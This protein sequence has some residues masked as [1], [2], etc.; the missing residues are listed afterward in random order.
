MV[1]GCKL[2]NIDESPKVDQS[3]YRSIIFNLL[4]LT[5]YIPNIIQE[6]GIVRIFQGAPRQSHLLAGKMILIYLRATMDYGFWYPIRKYF[7]LTIFIADW[8]G[9]V[10]DKKH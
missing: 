5:T 8:E 6:V 2:N 7:S 10:D 9:D 1:I 4:Y 3:L